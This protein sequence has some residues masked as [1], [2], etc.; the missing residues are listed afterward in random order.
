M[1]DYV[2]SWAHVPSFRCT[3][4]LGPVAEKGVGDPKGIL[5]LFSTSKRILGSKSHT[6]LQCLFWAA[7]YSPDNFLCDMKR[8]R[9]RLVWSENTRPSWEYNYNESPR[10]VSCHLHTHHRQRDWTQLLSL[11]STKDLYHLNYTFTH[12]TGH[13]NLITVGFN[14]IGCCPGNLSWAAPRERKV[15]IISKCCQ[16]PV[17]HA[18]RRAIYMEALSTASAWLKER[19]CFFRFLPELSVLPAYVTLTGVTVIKGQ[20]LYFVPSSSAF[21]MMCAFFHFWIVLKN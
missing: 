9:E 3:G 12:K 5:G 18:N 10:A 14:I 2:F 16:L 6:S 21:R 8:P 19:L 20:H 17:I 1:G 15:G 7:V 13:V 11:S 4:V